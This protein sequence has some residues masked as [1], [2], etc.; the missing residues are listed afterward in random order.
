[1]LLAALNADFIPR[2]RLT[3]G[4][5][6]VVTRRSHKRAA[7][8]L[9]KP[10]S[11]QDAEAHLFEITADL[12]IKTGTTGNEVTHLDSKLPMDFGKEY[13]SQI[14]A[15]HIPHTRCRQSAAESDA[16]HSTA[17]FNFLRHSFVHQVEEL[18]NAD[19]QINPSRL[20]RARQL[21][22]VQP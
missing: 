11:L 1:M 10:V 5:K 20:Q 18:W 12:G 7:G 2:K 14:E 6:D 8:C 21:C 4:A 19:E 9:R 13:L 22:H 3:N 16:C 15:E 17:T